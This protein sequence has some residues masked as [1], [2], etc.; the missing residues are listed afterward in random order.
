MCSSSRVQGPVDDALE[1]LI[2]QLM[3][4]GNIT[5]LP[6]ALERTIY[7]RLL[8]KAL[9]DVKV[10]LESIHI[11]FLGHEIKLVMTPY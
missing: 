7:R 9:Y 6:D 5:F 10:L 3:E 1:Q 2:H 8:R 11:Y 4:E